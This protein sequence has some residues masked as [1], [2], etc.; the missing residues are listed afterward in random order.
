MPRKGSVTKRRTPVDPKYGD[1]TVAK[2]ISAIMYDGK[3]S[4][5]EK[6]FY[7]AL[8]TVAEKT[9]KS[10]LEVF[11]AAMDNVKPMIEVRPRRVG[12]ATYQVP[13]EVSTFRRQSLAVRW[14][15]IAA[16]GRQGKSMEEKLAAEIL[17]AAQGRGG[18]IK[19]KEDTHKMA[20][21]NRAFAHYRW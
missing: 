7:G 19:K 20:E 10:P 17:D 9:G 8:N 11:Q 1:L 5:A 14:I 16:R 12:G 13:M 2:F 4:K 21:A 15:I 6:I 18:A 3:K